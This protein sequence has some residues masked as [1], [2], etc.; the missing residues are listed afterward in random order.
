MFPS[1]FRLNGTNSSPANTTN[2]ISTNNNNNSISTNSISTNSISTNNSNN[3]IPTLKPFNNLSTNNN[4]N[5]NKNS[6][7][8]SNIDTTELDLLLAHPKFNN[9]ISNHIQIK[10]NHEYNIFKNTIETTLN[11]KLL[12]AQERIKLDELKEQLNSREVFLNNLFNTVNQKLKQN[13]ELQKNIQI[14]MEKLNTLKRKH[15]EDISSNSVSVNNN[16][17][18]IRKLNSTQRQTFD[19]DETE[20]DSDIEDNI[21]IN[22]NV[23]V[24]N[25]LFEENNIQFTEVNEPNLIKKIYVMEGTF[26]DKHWIIKINNNCTVIPFLKT[27][28]PLLTNFYKQKFSTHTFSRK[29]HQFKLF[30]DYVK[31]SVR[32]E[33]GK[34][35]ILCLTG[36]GLLKL[37]SFVLNTTTEENNKV[38]HFINKY[39]CIHYFKPIIDTEDEF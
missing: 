30:E 31:L 38:L 16:I 28:E 20:S 26:D 37:A 24:V 4:N 17:V 6:N 2:S 15:L 23:T 19:N 5:S 3:S 33:C 1:P 34:R 9:L 13:S 12:I 25:N 35:Y 8:N 7:K 32:L 11:E 18:K 36:K 21:N 27:V 14:E 29:K 22:N 39:N 10:L